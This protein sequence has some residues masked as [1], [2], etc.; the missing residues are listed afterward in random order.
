MIDNDYIVNKLKLLKSE[1]INKSNYISKADN[2]I[3]LDHNSNINNNKLKNHQSKDYNNTNISEI[4]QKI[5]NEVQSNIELEQKKAMLE[6]ELEMI[7]INNKENI[8]NIENKVINEEEKDSD[9][10]TKILQLEAEIKKLQHEDLSKR[11]ELDKCVTDLKNLENDNFMINNKIKEINKLSSKKIYELEQVLASKIREL[12]NFKSETSAAIVLK[13]K[14]I[15]DEMSNITSEYNSKLSYTNKAKENLQLKLLKLESDNKTLIENKALKRNFELE[16]IKNKEKE[17]LMLLQKDF[18]LKKTMLLNTQKE[19]KQDITELQQREAELANKIEYILHNDNLAED[20]YS[21]IELDLKNK[22]KNI[23][24]DISSYNEKIKNL[25]NEISS[26]NQLNKSIIEDIK[27]LKSELREII[28]KNRKDINYNFSNNQQLY[29][30]LLKELEV[31]KNE[32]QE[33]KYNLDNATLENRNLKK[34]LT[35]INHKI[36]LN[37]TSNVD[38][39][40]NSYKYN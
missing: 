2:S 4:K 26:N 29:N 37:L 13:N 39:T 31:K 5:F 28:L 34:R 21:K 6:N 1:N 12:D 23:E 22:L 27:N 18:F 10:N 17:E 40:I 36:K 24:S 16:K 7:K 38:N 33:L 3:V 19:V 9:Y 35:D 8:N 30:E 14:K 11:N 15:T 20:E 32:E 25:K